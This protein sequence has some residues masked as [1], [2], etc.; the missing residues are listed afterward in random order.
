MRVPFAERPLWIKANVNQTGFYRVNY[1][2]SNWAALGHQLHTDHQALSAS[3]RAGLLDDT[4]TL[5][6]WVAGPC[7]GCAVW[8]ASGWRIC[9]LIS[10][11]HPTS[12]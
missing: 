3:D 6:R 10:L 1:E 12:S 5:A 2:A 9:H 4:F 11:V 7:R 8:N